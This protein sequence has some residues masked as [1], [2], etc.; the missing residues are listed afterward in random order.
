MPLIHFAFRQGL[1]MGTAK[2][3]KAIDDDKYKAG[4]IGQGNRQLLSYYI[5]YYLFC[6]ILVC[7][8]ELHD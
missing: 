6:N 1:I 5:T 2:A 7:V 4:K 3:K 8:V